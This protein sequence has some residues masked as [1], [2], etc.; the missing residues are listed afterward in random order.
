M[1]RLFVAFLFVL[2]S[3]PFML[4]ADRIKPRVDEIMPV[5]PYSYSQVLLSSPGFRSPAA[6]LLF[7]NICYLTGNDV[8]NRWKERKFTE[9]EWKR[10]IE[11]VG[12]V[13]K[14]DPY[15]F[16]PLYYLGAYVPWNIERN[17]ELLLRINSILING[18]RYVKDWRIPF[19]VAFNYFY[20]LK[21]KV[22]GA[23]YLKMASEME[24]APTY[25]KLLVPRFY[26]ESGKVDLAIAVTYEELKRAKEDTVKKELK[27]RLRALLAIKE[28]DR[29][30]EVYR[31]RFGRCPSDIQELV[32]LGII[33]A[34]PEDPYGGKFYIKKGKCSV[35]TTSNLRPI[36]KSTFS[37]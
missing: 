10:L 36:K 21:D 23:E 32:K 24:G 16:D 19:L 22:K 26:A 1:K 2:V 6:D 14:L 13:E 7:M 33:R 11:N 17:K 15:Y 4:K 12:V 5:L 29:A 35:W 27:K 18:S 20:F 34:L 9:E 28:L 37:R 8:F 30:L 3:V 25:L 31:K